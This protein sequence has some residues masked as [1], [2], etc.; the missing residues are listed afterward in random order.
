MNEQIKW[1]KASSHH[2]A[3]NSDSPDTLDK[4]KTW[5][6]NSLMAGDPSYRS[7]NEHILEVNVT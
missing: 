1:Q 3:L 5:T 6:T 7:H 2:S 4:V